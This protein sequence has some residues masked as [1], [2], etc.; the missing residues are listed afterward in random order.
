MYRVGSNL[1][2]TSDVDTEVDT[3]T[4]SNAEHKGSVRSN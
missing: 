2:D 1:M 4:S 3:L